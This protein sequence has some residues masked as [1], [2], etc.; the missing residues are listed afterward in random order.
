MNGLTTS[1]AQ[2]CAKF[3]DIRCVCVAPRPVLTRAAMAN[4]KTSLGYAAEPE[5]IVEMFLYLASPLARSITGTA[6]LMDGGRH[7]MFDKLHGENG[8]YGS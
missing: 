5:E 2:A 8:K 1:A 6:I 4:M 3:G 7:M